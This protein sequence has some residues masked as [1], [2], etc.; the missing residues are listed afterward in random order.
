MIFDENKLTTSLSEKK[1]LDVPME[2]ISTTNVN[3]R[4]EGLI[5]SNVEELSKMNGEFPEIYLGLLNDELII[6]D[7]YHRFAANSK[8][9]ISSIKA[10]VK[11]FDTMED[12]KKEAFLAN[13]N[14]GI[15]LSELDIAYNIYDFYVEKIKK[16]PLVTIRSVIKEYHVPDRRGRLLFYWAVIQKEILGNES[17]ELTNVSFMEDYAKIIS[18]KNEVIGNI[19]DEFK[20]NFKSFYEKYKVLTKQELRNAIALYLEGKDYYEEQERKKLEAEEEQRK[21]MEEFNNSSEREEERTLS[22]LSSLSAIELPEDDD[23]EE[24]VHNEVIEKLNQQYEA[25]ESSETSTEKQVTKHDNIEPV[26]VENKIEPVKTSKKVTLTKNIKEIFDNLK[27]IRMFV[28]KGKAEITKEDC[29]ALTLSA[30]LIEE[31]VT[32]YYE[33]N[34]AIKSA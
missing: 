24:I 11:K 3:P 2:L 21:F 30:D 9:N 19:S 12:L 33:E 27:V 28:L 22:G 13:I 29:E 6:V 32:S 23:D 34:N 10:F 25:T 18:E 14:H 4:R 8:N 7:G 5:E 1:I 26:K 20:R 17:A 31:L 16:D 15:K